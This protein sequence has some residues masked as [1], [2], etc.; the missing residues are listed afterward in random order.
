MQTQTQ[1]MPANNPCAWCGGEIIGKRADAVY[2][3]PLCKTR[4]RV[5]RDPERNRQVNR[6]AY[7]RRLERYSCDPEKAREADLA[8]KRAHYA[9]NKARLTAGSRRYYQKNKEKLCARARH[10]YHLKKLKREAAQKKEAQEKDLA[11]RT[12]RIRQDPHTAVAK[13]LKSSRDLRLQLWQPPGKAPC[14]Q[15]SP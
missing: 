12:R 8:Y 5:A 13:A 3:R 11:E 15:I 9:K 4:A 14:E 6:R 2:C 1:T 10:K 7:L